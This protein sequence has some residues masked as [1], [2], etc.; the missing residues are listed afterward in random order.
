MPVNEGC[1]RNKVQRLE[2]RLEVQAW[3][4]RVM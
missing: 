1:E 3:E 2:L 4:L